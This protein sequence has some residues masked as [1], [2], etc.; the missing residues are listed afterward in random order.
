LRAAESIQLIFV[1]MFLVSAWLRPLSLGQRVR[2]TGL[3][4]VAIA[5]ITIARYSAGWPTPR[6]S[7]VLR[8]WLPAVLL[9][10]PYWQVGQFF[11]SADSAVE[12]RLAAFDRRCFA[13]LGAEPSC[14]TISPV[15]AAY[16]QFA[17][18][19]VYPLIP[20]GLVALYLAGLRSRVDDYWIVV[21][22]ATYVCF[23]T[24]IFI[25]ALPPR[26]SPGYSCYRVPSTSLG[27]LNENI[28]SRASI[29]AITFPSAHVASALAAA[30][31][32]LKLEP[33]V[34][35]VFLWMAL[36]IAVATIVGGYHYV[37][38]VLVGIGIAV[39]VF[40]VTSCI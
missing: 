29:Q 14:V 32:L 31:I 37:A 13:L 36:S 6:V 23:I 8:D 35:L 17:Y 20:L 27:V 4:A 25:Q 5:A 7:S 21:L 10:V 33:R 19:M 11:N 15:L 28:L 30:L 38:D 24:T 22:G 2:V 18:M 9:L 12:H 16:I 26:L 3:A 40:V 34:G 1:T 39:L